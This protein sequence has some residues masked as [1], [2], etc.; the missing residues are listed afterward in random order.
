MPQE[1]VISP[2]GDDIVFSL[3][4]HNLSEHAD[5]LPVYTEA[6]EIVHSLVQSP[7]YGLFTREI[8]CRK[9]KAVDG[10]TS[11]AKYGMGKVLIQECF[12]IS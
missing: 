5:L 10:Y 4:F 7:V 8:C 2:S 3:S 12:P 9:T 6:K 1:K 11:I